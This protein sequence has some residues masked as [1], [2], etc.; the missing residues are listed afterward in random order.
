M[1]SGNIK[2]EMKKSGQNE[3]YNIHTEKRAAER[4]ELGNKEPQC[5]GSYVV[6]HLLKT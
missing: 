1:V 5:C 3:K 4:L 2:Q 6:L